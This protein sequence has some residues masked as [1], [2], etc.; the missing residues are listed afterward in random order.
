MGIPIGGGGGGGDPQDPGPRK[1][2]S[3]A[4]CGLRRPDGTSE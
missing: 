4:I 2:I 1:A 3:Q